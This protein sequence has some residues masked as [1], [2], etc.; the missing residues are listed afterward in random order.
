MGN[1]ALSV[2]VVMVVAAVMSG[3]G[4]GGIGGG[5]GCGGS[6]NE[7]LATLLVKVL[8]VSSYPTPYHL[9]LEEGS[10]RELLILK[11][12]ADT[13]THTHTHTLATH[14]CPPSPRPSPGA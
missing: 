3:V 1:A 2:G 14:T 7:I 5:N 13:H 9:P 10:K 6:G 11:T 12:F 8:R 4:S